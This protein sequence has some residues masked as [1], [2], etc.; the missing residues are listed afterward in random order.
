[1]KYI[2]DFEDGNRIDGIYYCKSKISTETKNGKPYD[3]LILQDKTG[4]IDTKV[5]S[6]Y[7]PGIREYEA[8]DF[9]EVR[10][11]VIIF[12]NAKQF[13]ANSIRKC[14]EDEYDPGDYMP[15]TSKD[16][17]EM[18]R[19]LTGLVESVEN[20]Y[21]KLLL[22]SFF[23]DEETAAT[24]KKSSAAK[25]IHHAFIGGL[26]EHTLSVTKLCD[27][28]CGNYPVLNRDLLVTCALLHDIGKIRELSLYPDNDYT[29]A[30]QLVGH[31]II[32]AQM[33][34]EHMDK[35]SGF[36]EI[37]KN[38]VQH[39][40]LAHHG[41][42]EFGSPKKPA[43][44]EALALSMADNMDA[45]IETFSEAINSSEQKDWM[46]FNK[47]LDSNVRKTEQV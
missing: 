39:C 7:D 47:F 18:Y 16:I 1:M 38:E 44:I 21:L 41:Q 22:E 13:R 17:D 43:L 19:E 45:K 28:M 29:D 14:S 11:D 40:I 25:T 31:I 10:G 26:L 12:N 5:W 34:K 9:I 42:L 20:P 30:G 46:G 32:G 6:P 8:G 37:L 35:I 3:S 4:T 23:G 27:F 36:P 15:V 33:A 24:F 2:K